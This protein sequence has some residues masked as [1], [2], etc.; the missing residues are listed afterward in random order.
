MCAK[1]HRG[2]PN[3]Y[4]VERYKTELLA[5]EGDQGGR[6]IM[7]KYPQEIWMMEVDERELKDIDQPADLTALRLELEIRDLSDIKDSNCLKHKGR[8]MK[9]KENV[10]EEVKEEAGKNNRRITSPREALL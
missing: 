2:S 6:Q 9:Q 5:L 3:L 4:S 7:Q 10:K 8:K 1:G